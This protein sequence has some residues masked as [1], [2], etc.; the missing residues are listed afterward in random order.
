MLS[1]E[2]T[3]VVHVELPDWRAFEP[4]DC[5]GAFDYIC[6]RCGWLAW[7]SEVSSRCLVCE[8]NPVVLLAMD[9]AFPPVSAK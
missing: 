3:I 2:L 1:P 6:S 5:S 9:A 8:D 7:K 4:V